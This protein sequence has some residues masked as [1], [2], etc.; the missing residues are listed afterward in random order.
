[1]HQASK[2]LENLSL[3]AP[4]DITD[5]VNIRQHR[6]LTDAAVSSFIPPLIIILL[7]SFSF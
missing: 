4:V 5:K 6:E 3:A 2:N 7:I 1:M